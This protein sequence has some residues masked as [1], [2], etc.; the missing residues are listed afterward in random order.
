MSGTSSFTEGKILS[1]LLKFAVPVI[2][3]LILQSLYGAVDLLV[4]GQFACSADVSAVATGSQVLSTLTNIIAGL[5]MGTTI[6]LGQQIGEGKTK[7]AGHTMGA[8]IVFF[9]ITAVV[10]SAVMLLNVENI[11]NIMQAPAEA[12]AATC[13]YIRICSWG[14][15]VVVAYNLLGSLFRGL[16]NSK[17]P[18][19]A[20]AVAAVINIFGDLY[21]VS[22][23]HM[24]AA[25]AAIATVASQGIAVGISLIIILRIKLPFEF[26]RK[27]ISFK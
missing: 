16:G 2:L 22:V 3:A 10:C 1:P 25:G 8:S 23:L 9:G 6:L 20:V 17:I 13:D 12:Y 14:M 5:S 4:V 15:I 21:L 26:N 11:A 19:I 27:F 24:G 18:L 7:E